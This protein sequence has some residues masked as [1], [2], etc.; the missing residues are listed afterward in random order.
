MS[1]ISGHLIISDPSAVCSLN[2]LQSS[3]IK[4]FILFEAA[5]LAQNPQ[6]PD[7]VLNLQPHNINFSADIEGE[8][9]QPEILDTPFCQQSL[10]VLEAKSWSQRLHL[11]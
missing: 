4:R 8:V 1:C 6:F 10:I 5:V 2:S 3:G 11:S 7:L 9:E